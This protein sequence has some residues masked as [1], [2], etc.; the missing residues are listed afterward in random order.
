MLE[1]HLRNCPACRQFAADQRLLW[2]ELDQW[3]PEVISEDFDRKLY[4]K[5]DEH[6]RKSVW[7]RLFASVGPLAEGK[8]AISL[9]AACLMI[10]IGIAFHSPEKSSPVPPHESS[11]AEMLEPSKSSA[12][13]KIWRCSSSYLPFPAQLVCNLKNGMRFV[14]ILVIL[15]TAAAASA[16]P[17]RGPHHSGPP[18]LHMLERP[19]RMSPQ[20]RSECCRNPAGSEGNRRGATGSLQ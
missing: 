20:Q 6:Q 12:V 7:R 1:R 16:Q 8:P 19:N 2:S 5:I 4:G 15:S 11:R 9:A 13:S 3:Q 14:F 10:V 17:K 18:P